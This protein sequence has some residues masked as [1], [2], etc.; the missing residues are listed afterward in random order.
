MKSVCKPD[1]E[2]KQSCRLTAVICFIN[3]LSSRIN[4]KLI[5][6]MLFQKSSP[7]GWRPEAVPPFWPVFLHFVNIDTSSST[8]LAH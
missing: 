8:T 6:V 5:N 1:K 2:Q 7:G 3:L 4:R